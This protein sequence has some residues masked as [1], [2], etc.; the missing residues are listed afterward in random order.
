M[1]IVYLLAFVFLTGC[2]FESQN[3]VI[4]EVGQATYLINQKNSEAFAVLGNELIKLEERKEAPLKTG[5]LLNK[6][7]TISSGRLEVD[8]KVKFMGTKAFYIMDAEPVLISKNGETTVDKSNREWFSSQL[9]G[10]EGFNRINITISILDADGFS[11]A[12]RTVNLRESYT[13]MLDYNDEVG[14][15]KYEGSFYVDPEVMEFASS[16]SITYNL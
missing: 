1:K 15:Y 3:V 12:L 7:F 6:S 2:N 11:L 16:L 14:S 9:K 13:N 5:R 10:S 4:Q 8:L